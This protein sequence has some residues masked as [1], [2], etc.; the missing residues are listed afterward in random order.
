MLEQ[1]IR[2]AA[3]GDDI[4]GVVLCCGL[5]KYADRIQNRCLEVTVVDDQCA[6][7]IDDGNGSIA[8]FISGDP[9]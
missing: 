9:A 6:F 4:V 7:Q 3:Y 8:A 1:Q 2:A 5:S